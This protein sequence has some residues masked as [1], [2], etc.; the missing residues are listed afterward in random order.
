M[1]GQDGN[2]LELENFR[3]NFPSCFYALMLMN[4][5]SFLFAN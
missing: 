2:G 3:L 1:D 5:V 4:M